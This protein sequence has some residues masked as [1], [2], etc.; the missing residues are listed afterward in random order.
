MIVQCLGLAGDRPSIKIAVAHTTC[1]HAQRPSTQD[2]VE[3]LHK[4]NRAKPKATLGEGGRW[5][6]KRWGDKQVADA[7]HKKHYG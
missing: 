2:S 6:L 7:P 4:R 3:R 1:D 5:R